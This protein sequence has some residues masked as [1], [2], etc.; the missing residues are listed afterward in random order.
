MMTSHT[1]H[2]PATRH[3]VL[4]LV[5]LMALV[6]ASFTPALAQTS[7]GTIISNQASAVYTDSSSNNYSTVS[8]TVTVTVANVSGLRI[9]PD[10]ASNP[11]VVPGQTNVDYV[12][13]V[14]NI[15][16]FADQVRFLANGQSMTVG[17]PGTITAAV[18]DNGDNVIGA[19]DTNILTNGADVLHALAQ[20]SSAV[21]IVRLTISAAATS[22]QT[23]QVFLGD[24]A[25]GSGFDNQAA[26][27]SANEVRTVSAASVNGLREARGDI[28]AA[29]QNDVQLRAVLTVPA[30]PAALGSNITYGLQACNDG[31]RSATAMSLG[32]FSGIF[33]VAPVPV[34]TILSATNA[35][36]AGTLYTTSALTTAPQSATWST[37]AP[38]PLSSTTRVA[39]NTGATLAGSGTCSASVP[40]IL[41]ITTSNASTPIYGIVDA[42]ATNTV[43][44]VVTDQSGD[45][46][47]GKGD[48]NADFNEP[49]FGGT[50]S[51]TQGFQLPTL[52]QALG[53]VLIGPSGQPAAVGPTN[54]NDDFTNR[55]VTTG[56]AGIT[57][58]AGPQTPACSTNASG[59]I[60]FTNTV[61]NTGNANDTFTLTAPTV[62]S[63]FTVEIS[64]N[65][66][67]SY[68]TVSGGGN[69]TVAVAFGG[70]ANILVRVT[71]PSGQQILTGL[72]TIIQAAS[73]NTPASTNQTIDRLFTG[74]VR[75]DKA[76]NVIDAA[77]NPSANIPG[78]IIEYVI[79]YTNVMTAAAAGSG[80]SSLTATNLVITEDGTAGG[81]NWASFTTQV[82]S[83]APSDST[84]GVIT[85][86]SGGA[87]TV[88]TNHLKDTVASLAPGVTGTFRFRRLIN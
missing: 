20:N 53:A 11:T 31:N 5:A 72:A 46:I 79:T 10:G 14:T 61:Q 51:A 52:L 85:D 45:T 18:V 66:G 42:F 63:G 9:T 76:A 22:G 36:P 12:F 54:N 44:A 41:T 86:G 55:S 29:V 67:T 59:V 75:L 26:D 4:K 78:A 25:S 15:G 83:P 43:S 65:G 49:L 39:I 32:A 2:L 57:P 82:I 23:V 48:G 19:G 35:F 6:C 71:A 40:M 64:T 69:T 13:T 38:A 34:G 73:L 8:N 70:T 3:A 33:V 7:G 28:S 58:C 81:N 17:G 24:T 74:F 68:T 27:S 30:G 77:G 88:L 16:N 80:N 56:I 84:G 1:P 87:V 62:P 60:V 21:V 37:T 50:V 47:A